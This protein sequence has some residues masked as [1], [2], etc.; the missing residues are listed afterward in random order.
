MNIN[1]NI[2]K[3]D[4]KLEAAQVHIDHKNSKN[5][6]VT[7]KN[8]EQIGGGIE[9][10]FSSIS[11][12]KIIGE[13]AIYTQV[14]DKKI[15]TNQF[16]IDF[17]SI[18]HITQASV[19]GHL[20][21]IVKICLEMKKNN[22]Y[23]KSSELKSLEKEYNIDLEEKKY[24]PILVKSYLVS[25][26]DKY[27]IDT[28]LLYVINIVANFITPDTL[29]LLHIDI[30]GIPTKAKMLAQRDRRYMGTL[31]DFVEKEFYKKNMKEIKTNAYFYASEELRIR[32]ER[33]LI[34]PKTYFMDML[35]N[36][37]TSKEFIKII[38]GFA[39]NLK[40]Y[41]VGDPKQERGEGE[42][43]IVDYIMFNTPED[44]NKRI[45]IYSPDSDMPVLGLLMGNRHIKILRQ[46]Q[47]K[48]SYDIIHIPKLRK[49]L[50]AY[51]QKNLDFKIE[52]KRIMKDIAFIFS[53]FGND[54]I[55]KI[56]SINVKNDFEFILMYYKLVLSEEKTYL[57]QQNNNNNNDTSKITHS[58]SLDILK[59]YITLLANKEDELLNSNYMSSTYRD[60]N[61]IQK[62]FSNIYP[63]TKFS[64]KILADHVNNF[65]DKYYLLEKYI[66][67]K[68]MPVTLQ[69]DSSFWLLIS[70]LVI[71]KDRKIQ[72]SV[73]INLIK[74][75][76]TK[77]INNVK[78]LP[79]LRL[80]LQKYNKSLDDNYHLQKYKEKY[81]TK[82]NYQK[83][84]YKWN[85]GLEPYYSLLGFGGDLGRVDVEK[86]MKWN[87]SKLP[88]HKN[89]YNNIGIGSNSIDKFVSE[90]LKGL[91]WV[92]NYYYTFDNNISHM[93]KWT[94][95]YTKAPL[96]KDIVNFLQ[97]KQQNYISD[98]DSEIKKL[99]VPLDKYFTL[100]QHIQFITPNVLEYSV[101]L[102]SESNKD[103]KKYQL[104]ALYFKKV[105]KLVVSLDKNVTKYL[106]CSGVLHTNKCNLIIPKLYNVM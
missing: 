89:Y 32:W 70:K 106:N 46:N 68:T 96:L 33:G 100:D 5:T 62:I 36:E 55:P 30:D 87:N 90:Y 98:L 18:V 4:S 49:N 67:S 78:K 69:N 26:I 82:N 61:K 38:K 34:S 11:D 51:F 101:I 13:E 28:V 31:N 103:D 63:I 45:V 60:Y 50:F 12:N 77:F 83:D 94:Y 57:I 6:K 75:E 27:I 1:G 52:E 65:L 35:Y 85:N 43:K 25:K 53:V 29:E 14:L 9:L 17:N 8:L 95:N 74:T 102:D 7:N 48:S 24:D 79:K 19:T 54:F 20:N 22:D 41:I 88:D 84:L 81:D 44:L 39:V 71:W 15:K 59:K 93:S 66:S 47:Q 105:A 99:D 56:P 10:F 97:N 42:K 64:F 16:Y 21:R 23:K 3:T 80:Q 91:I 104:T 76:F 2:I 37:L 40:T 92:F 58:F 86:N 72:D 73:D